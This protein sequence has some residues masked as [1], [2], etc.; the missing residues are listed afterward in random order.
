LLDIRPERLRKLRGWYYPG[1]APHGLA[2]MKENQRWNAL[3]A[4]LLGYRLVFINVNLDDAQLAAVLGR[5]LLQNGSHGF[6][7]TTPGCKKIDQHGHAG[8]IDEFRK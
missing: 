6:A 1:L 2:L 8:T 7:G 3:Y 4:V 5:Y